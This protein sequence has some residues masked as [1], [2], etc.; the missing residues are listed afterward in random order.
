MNY[1]ITGEF[2]SI[3]TIRNITYMNIRLEQRK[4]YF[5]VDENPEAFEAYGA[6]FPKKGKLRLQG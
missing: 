4:D 5:V 1:H 2:I 3:G 6:T